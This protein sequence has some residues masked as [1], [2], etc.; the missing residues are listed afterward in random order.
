MP[1]TSY[2]FHILLSHSR[3]LQLLKLLGLYAIYQQS[4]VCIGSGSKKIMALI[5]KS[6]ACFLF[7]FLSSISQHF[8][9]PFF[10]MSF[11]IFSVF[12][13]TFLTNAS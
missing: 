13:L 12:A 5:K 8:E 6:I 2:L 9:W 1:R 11:N 3:K 10:T 4:S 7:V